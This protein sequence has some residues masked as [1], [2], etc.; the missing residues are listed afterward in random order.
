MTVITC[1]INS[2]INTSWLPAAQSTLTATVA[3]W[4]RAWDTLTMFEELYGVRKVVSSIPDRGNIVPR[5]SFSSE[6]GDWYMVSSSEHAFQDFQILNL[7]RTLS[8]W[9]SSN[10]RPSAPLLYEVANHVKQLPFRPLLLWF[11]SD[12][13]LR[14]LF[15]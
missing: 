15:V 10:Y 8:S 12:N 13:V 9:G 11:S 14:R 2:H 1:P 6:P 7:F 3:E 4:V 5:M